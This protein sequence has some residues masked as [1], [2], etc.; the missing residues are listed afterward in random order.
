MRE[1]KSG[2]SEDTKGGKPMSEHREGGQDL[3]RKDTGFLRGVG[4]ELA[5]SRLLKPTRVF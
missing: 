2:L 4:L 3:Q 1:A 5:I